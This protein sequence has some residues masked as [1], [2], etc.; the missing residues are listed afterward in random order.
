LLLHVHFLRTSSWCQ[1][2]SVWG[3]TMKV[4]HRSRGITRLAAASTNRSSRRR[5]KLSALTTE[6]P[7]FMTQDDV[8]KLEHGDGGAS[9]DPAEEAL[10]EEVDEQERRSMLRV[11]LSCRIRVFVPHT[12]Q[13][14]AAIRRRVIMASPRG[15][16]FIR[17]HGALLFSSPLERAEL[18]LARSQLSGNV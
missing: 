9:T 7:D 12:F 10:K 4:L 2:S 6:D 1:R 11:R 3:L 17:S 18:H 5:S 14:S 16:G 15:A 8:L 13:P